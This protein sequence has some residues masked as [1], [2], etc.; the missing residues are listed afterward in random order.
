MWLPIYFSYLARA[1]AE[2]AQFD[3]ASRSIGE[4]MLAI[5]TTKERCWESEIHRVAGEITLVSP[6]SDAQ[7]AEAHFEHALTVA[8]AQRAKSWELR[9][10]I[11]MAR[12]W[13]DQGKR[14]KARDLLAPL[15]DLF[16]E[17]FDTLDLKEARALLTGLAL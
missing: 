15:Y 3:D 13:D 4:A 2:L 8:R 10:T 5:E 7:K 17:G 12:L 6:H 14:D 1:H 9:A 16:T 11:S